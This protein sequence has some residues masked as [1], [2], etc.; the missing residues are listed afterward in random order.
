MLVFSKLCFALCDSSFA[1]EFPQGNQFRI[2]LKWSFLSLLFFASRLSSLCHRLWPRRWRRC[3]RPMPCIVNCCSEL[4]V[5]SEMWCSKASIRNHCFSN[6]KIHSDWLTEWLLDVVGVVA[7]VYCATAIIFCQ[8]NIVVTKIW[9][10]LR[11]FF[12]CSIVCDKHPV[13]VFSRRRNK[14]VL[15]K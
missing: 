3:Q 11:F 7:V 12:L 8:H 9:M 14:K 4:C 5:K 6:D 1:F 13:Q 10:S 15:W 2:H